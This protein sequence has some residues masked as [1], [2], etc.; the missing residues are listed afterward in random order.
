ML[1]WRRHKASP[2]PPTRP[3]FR[4]RNSRPSSPGPNPQNANRGF[5]NSGQSAA[6]TQTAT[7]ISKNRSPLRACPARVPDYGL[8]RTENRR[9]GVIVDLTGLED[10]RDGSGRVASRWRQVCSSEGKCG[11]HHAAN[12]RAARIDQARMTLRRWGRPQPSSAAWRCFKRLALTPRGDGSCPTAK[13]GA[14]GGAGRGKGLEPEQIAR[15]SPGSGTPCPWR[16][17]SAVA[18][19]PRISRFPSST[20]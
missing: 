14:P 13:T 8:H 2:A 5:A 7:A 20:G 18:L 1:G 3:S 4:A 17:V 10:R 16:C 19:G 6:R 9:A 11:E 15:I 12:H